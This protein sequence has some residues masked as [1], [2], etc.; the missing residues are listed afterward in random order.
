MTSE[1]RRPDEDE[2]PREDERPEDMPGGAAG[3]AGRGNPDAAENSP[4]GTEGYTDS[5]DEADTAD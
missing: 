3:Y 1:R 5:R 2:K 4:G